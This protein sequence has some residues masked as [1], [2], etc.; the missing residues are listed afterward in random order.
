M[1]VWKVICRV[2][3]TFEI[4]GLMLRRAQWVVQ[5]EAVSS[6]CASGLHCTRASHA[7]RLVRE[8]RRGAAAQVHS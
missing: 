5:G 7:R 1:R 6:A 3:P 2:S 4:T 8:E